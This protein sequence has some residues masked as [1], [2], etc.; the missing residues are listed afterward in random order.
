MHY[1]LCYSAKEGEILAATERIS[2]PKSLALA[3][4]ISLLL[5]A[6]A[7]PSPRPDEIL[8]PC[9]ERGEAPAIPP[10]VDARS[11]AGIEGLLRGARLERPAVDA[12]AATLVAHLAPRRWEELAPEAQEAWLERAERLA[13]PEGAA[14]ALRFHFL[15]E[16][17]RW[18]LD[19]RAAQPTR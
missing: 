7:P 13:A 11:P 19:L 12:D 2:S 5:L 6:C 18:R 15:R 8:R 10:L 1:Q 3:C 16:Q 9:A 14:V 4:A 17:G